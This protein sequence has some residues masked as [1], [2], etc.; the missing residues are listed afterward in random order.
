MDAQS[1]IFRTNIGLEIYSAE[2]ALVYQLS[3]DPKEGK[4]SSKHQILQF[5]TQ[6]V[7]CTYR[8]K[9]L[10]AKKVQS[11]QPNR[12]ISDENVSAKPWVTRHAIKDKYL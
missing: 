1:T 9:I 8:C 5:K 2:Q 7:Q 3:S 6:K 4:I 11:H 12:H 10:Y